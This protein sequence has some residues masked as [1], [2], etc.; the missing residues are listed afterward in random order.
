MIVLN[1][2]ADKVSL[3]MNRYREMVPNT[4]KAKDIISDKELEIKNILE[5]PAKTA[6]ILEIK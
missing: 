2:N 3:D 1:K 6:M 5:V 4:F